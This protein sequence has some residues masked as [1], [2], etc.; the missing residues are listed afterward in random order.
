MRMAAAEEPEEPL[1]LE[2]LPKEGP[3]MTWGPVKGDHH[4]SANIIVSTGV[5]AGGSPA[6][7]TCV[8]SYK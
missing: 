1:Q 2:V 5:V 7:L 3:T 6:L 8:S 4:S